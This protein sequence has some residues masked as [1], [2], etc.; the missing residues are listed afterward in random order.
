MRTCGILQISQQALWAGPPIHLKSE[1]HFVS[2]PPWSPLINWG[3][4]QLFLPCLPSLGRVLALQR[5]VHYSVLVWWHK[6]A[7]NPCVVSKQCLLQCIQ[8]KFNNGLN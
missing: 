5:T 3:L 1:N 8:E 2:Q 6:A 4:K 7:T